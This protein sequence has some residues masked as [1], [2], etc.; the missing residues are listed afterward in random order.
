[1]V[2]IEMSLSRAAD[3]KVVRLRAARSKDDLCG[4]TPEQRRDALPRLLYGGTGPAANLMVARG[5]AEVLAQIRKHR[6]DHFG[7]HRGRR[8]VIKIDGHDCLNLLRIRAQDLARLHAKRS[9][10]GYAARQE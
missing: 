6:V 2:T 3:G 9:A 4:R 7:E 10:G 1:M 8:V 5:I